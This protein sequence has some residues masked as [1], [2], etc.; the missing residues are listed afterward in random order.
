MNNPASEDFGSG[1]QPSVNFG[2]VPNASATFGTVPNT[3]EAFRTVRNP[4]E[5]TDNHTLTVRD[6]A[7]LFESAGVG[8]TERSIIN[9]CRPNRQ[10]VARLD[11]FFDENEGHYYITQGSVDRAVEEERAKQSGAGHPSAVE[12]DVPH[13]A[14]K[15]APREPASSD[16][17]KEL[18]RQNR[19]LE[20]ATRAK[21]FY[22][23]RLEKEREKYVDQLV[24]MSRYVGELETQVHQLGGAPR[25][26][27]TLPQGSEAFGAMP[28]SEAGGRPSFPQGGIAL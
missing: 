10:G 16:H 25:G 19:D 13:R 12:P 24:G 20:I 21:D 6:V 27:R 14:E 7:R 15:A 11:S 23:E 2:N 5:R 9:W 1:P 28:R 4:S 26:D 3:S 8:R 22:L 17:V 18:E